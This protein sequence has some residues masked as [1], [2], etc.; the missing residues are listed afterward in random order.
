MKF[1]AL[2]VILG[3]IVCTAAC[4]DEPQA[5]KDAGAAAVQ[6]VAA[7]DAALAGS[8]AVADPGPQVDVPP[9][10]D[11]PVDDPDAPLDATLR[12]APDGCT[13]QC[14][15][16]DG[17]PKIC[18]GNGCNNVCGFCKSGFLCKPDGT[19]CEELCKP[20]CSAAMKCG[21]NGCGGNCGTCPDAFHC[22]IDFLCHEDACIGACGTNDCGD[23]G[24][25]VSCGDCAVG[26]F[27]SS[28]KCKP[29]PCKGIPK[30]GSCAGDILTFCDMTSGTAKKGLLD[31]TSKG[32]NK[33]C[34]W[35]AVT[36][37]NDCIEKAACV[38]SCKTAD[39]SSKVC[40]D[41][42]C[43]KPCGNC[44][45]G[46]VCKVTSCQATDGAPC[47]ASF[48]P[49]G[50]C[51]GT[52]LVYCSAGTTPTIQSTDCAAVEGGKCQYISAKGKFDC[53]F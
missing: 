23:D 4:G 2:L 7:E 49:A 43:G 41:N 15:L 30:E 36:S 28:G 18:G 40:G 37:F 13:P 14:A 33:T 44:T 27:C 39:G 53:V 5:K 34:G 10:E 20:K 11:V 38:P 3:L 52:T 17:T 26:D 6:D 29:G 12:T 31:C 45:T 24:C 47:G 9:A 48:P 1:D 35:N 22:G 50:K 16:A 21:D 51:D 25:G 8:D 32:P 19:A 42:G 46:W